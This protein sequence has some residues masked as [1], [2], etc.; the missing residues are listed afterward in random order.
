M[1]L[2]AQLVVKRFPTQCAL[3]SMIAGPVV[4]GGYYR[5]TRGLRGGWPSSQQTGNT[6]QV[7]FQLIEMALVVVLNDNVWHGIHLS[8]RNDVDVIG[9]KN[10]CT[11]T[12]FSGS[13]F[14]GNKMTFT[15][16]VKDR[17]VRF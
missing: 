17:L 15:A 8:F 1:T 13:S 2:S 14:D 6:G 3:F 11:F 7:L 12:G 9:L 10:G 5:S 16:G 4:V